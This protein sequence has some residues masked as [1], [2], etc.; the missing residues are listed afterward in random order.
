M[1]PCGQVF[2]PE[3]AGIPCNQPDDLLSRALMQH[4]TGQQ[5]VSGDSG[6]G[7]L[8]HNGMERDLKAAM[9]LQAAGPRNSPSWQGERN[10]P[11]LGLTQIASTNCITEVRLHLEA[12]CRLV[13]PQVEVLSKCKTAKKTRAIFDDFHAK[14]KIN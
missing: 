9:V 8:G 12:R 3:N 11:C 2:Q 7:L 1:G 4:M 14:T 13:I 10:T 5:I 6:D